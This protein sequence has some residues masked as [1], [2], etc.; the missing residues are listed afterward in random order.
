MTTQE[1]QSYSAIQKLRI[2]FPGKKF[3]LLVLNVLGLFVISLFEMVGVAAILPIVNLASDAPI[4]G[5]LKTAADFFGNPSRTTLIAIFSVILV[6]AFVLKAIFSLIIKRWSLGFTATQQS[7]TS[8]RLLENFM[9]ES[10]LTYRRRTTASV[11]NTV[12]DIVGQT[13]GA[14]VN[15]IISFLGDILSIIVLMIMLLVIMPVPA[16]AAFIY[17]GITAFLL[18]F[19]LRRKNV[20]QGRIVLEATRGALDAALDAIVG[21]REIRMH[22]AEKRYV[23]RYQIKRMDSVNASMRNIYL[24][25]FPKYLLEVIFIIGI[26]GLMLLMSITDGENAA[27]MLILLVGACVRILPNYTRVVASLG[28]IRAGKNASDMLVEELNRLDSSLRDLSL[29]ELEPA[30]HSIDP[31]NK[32]IKPISIRVDNVSFA[33]PDGE[34]NVLENINL[35]IPMGTSVAFV[36]GS[37]SGKTTL[38]DL[39][40]GL[41]ETNEG[42]ILQNGVSIQEDLHSWHEHIGYVPQ[43]VFV[44]DSTVLEAVAFGL[45]EDEIDVERVKKCL[46]MAELTDVIDSLEEGMYTMVGEH[47]TRLSGGQRQR[48]GIARALY[49][50]PSV[51]V[52]DE[53][54]SALDNE[55]EHKITKTIGRISQDITVI[56]VAHRLSTVR[57]VDQLVYLSQGHIVNRGTFKEVQ[58]DNAEFARLVQLGQLPE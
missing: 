48:L 2:F 28:V 44:A 57:D 20:E 29:P 52:M 24:Q 53:A 47:G 39:I 35:D 51:L 43:D 1:Q 3:Y 14:F 30:D 34:K 58:R 31:V 49:R 42:Q 38:V 19:L 27:P 40:L 41:F 18:Q 21:F 22:N 12:N 15:G 54:T 46:D 55:T 56:I 17:F 16:L 6:L 37:G 50:N 10:Y 26:A 13:Y 33:Y 8:V 11:L 25:D 23:D 4:E 32:E 45:R 5:Y 36:G 9:G 7:A